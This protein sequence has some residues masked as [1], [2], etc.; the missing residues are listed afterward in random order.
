MVLYFILKEQKER[1]S[2]ASYQRKVFD[3]VSKKKIEMSS[4]LV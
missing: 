1:L 2:N 4:T 3:S